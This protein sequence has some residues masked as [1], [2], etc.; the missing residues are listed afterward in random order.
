MYTSIF[1]MKVS[2]E[3]YLLLCKSIKKYRNKIKQVQKTNINW[4]KKDLKTIYKS[5]PVSLPVPS[6]KTKFLHFII[7]I[8]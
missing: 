6:L 2:F 8:T 7:K 3:I 4:R 5:L 1:S